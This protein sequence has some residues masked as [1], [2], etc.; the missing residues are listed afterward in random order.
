I[1][2]RK[3]EDEARA[4]A[5][6]P[7][8]AGQGGEPDIPGR[9]GAREGRTLR[10]MV[11]RAVRRGQIGRNYTDDG[12]DHQ[13]ATWPRRRSEAYM[14]CYFAKLEPDNDGLLV[15]F[16]DIPEAMSAGSTRPEAL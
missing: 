14:M 2:V 3:P 16:P 13:K 8:Q 15:T 4:I 6:A 1:L 7:A 10:R 5:S 12:K 9:Y 11:R